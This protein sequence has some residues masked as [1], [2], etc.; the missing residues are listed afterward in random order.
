MHVHPALEKGITSGAKAIGMAASTAIGIAASAAGSSGF[1]PGASAA[2]AIGPYVAGLIEQ[3]GKIIKNI[4]NVPSSFLVGNATG[5]TTQNP[6]GSTQRSTNASGGTTID[7]SHHGDVYT[8]N[9]DDYFHQMDIRDSQKAQ[10]IL[11]RFG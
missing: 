8:Q 11:G 7:Q 9:L 10:G 4:A 6:Y 3:G 1:A 2:G 5:G